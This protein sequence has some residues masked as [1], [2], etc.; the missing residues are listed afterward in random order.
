[1]RGMYSSAQPARNPCPLHCRRAVLP[2][3]G[4]PGRPQPAAS[5]PCPGHPSGP[6]SEQN[7]WPAQA[8]KDGARANCCYLIC[9]RPPA[10]STRTELADCLVPHHTHRRARTSA[11]PPLQAFNFFSMAYRDR[12]KQQHPL[13]DQKVGGW[14]GSGRVTA[15]SVPRAA[16]NRQG[17]LDGAGL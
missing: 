7:G 13:D 2:A 11:A 10:S 1:M 3:R 12:A 15:P 6:S 9:S 4:V 5:I 14:R 8:P 17:A 16:F